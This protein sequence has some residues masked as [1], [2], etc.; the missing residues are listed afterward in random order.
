[1]LIQSPIGPLNEYNSYV[2]VVHKRNAS[3]LERK[4][5]CCPDY[6]FVRHLSQCTF[7]NISNYRSQPTIKAAPRIC[8]AAIKV[9]AVLHDF[10]LVLNIK[11]RMWPVPFGTQLQ[12][13]IYHS[14]IHCF[15]AQPYSLW[16]MPDKSHF[17]FVNVHSCY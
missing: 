3:S 16:A 17:F 6:G 7:K 12:G 11:L 13:I 15:I 2:T 9:Y 5:C 4:T 10:G 1:M 8:Q 14:D